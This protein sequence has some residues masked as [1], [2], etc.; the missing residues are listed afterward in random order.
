MPILCSHQL[1]PGITIPGRNH[2][3]RFCYI[4]D[5]C[6]WLRNDPTINQ[7]EVPRISAQ[8]AYE[9]L[10]C[11][12]PWDDSEPIEAYLL[13]EAV[14]SLP[15]H[16]RY[17]NALL[18]FEENHVQNYSPYPEGTPTYVSPFRQIQAH[19]HDHQ[20]GLGS[21]LVNDGYTTRIGGWLWSP[22]IDPR[23]LRAP[24]PS[25]EPAFRASPTPSHHYS[26][27]SPPPA[28]TEQTPS[29]GELRLISDS[30]PTLAAAACERLR[31]LAENLAYPEPEDVPDLVPDDGNPIDSEL[32][33][34]LSTPNENQENKPYIHSTATRYNLRPR[35]RVPAR[36]HQCLSW[37]RDWPLHRIPH[38]PAVTRPSH[39]PAEELERLLDTRPEAWDE[40]EQCFARS[41]ARSLRN[42]ASENCMRTCAA[43]AIASLDSDTMDFD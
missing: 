13:E 23:A 37:T 36:T 7:V 28:T 41:V 29:V 35:A 15:G 3:A 27:N 24:T 9:I 20:P 12:T 19:D 26:G 14:M 34:L 17:G 32:D 40:R 39:P 8:T 21:I 4:Y 30:L 42:A 16:Y 11:L 25:P 38:R 18:L 1:P 10:N 5:Y 6:G 31:E 33:E 43:R 2:P 22:T